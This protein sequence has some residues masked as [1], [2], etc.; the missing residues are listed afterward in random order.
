M[1][2]EPWQVTLVSTTIGS[3][4]GFSSSFIIEWY[5]KKKPPRDA[6]RE[7]ANQIVIAAKDNVAT[8]QNV[9]DLLEGRLEKE[10]EYYDGL[11]ERSKKDCQN[12]ITDMK[13]QYD[14]TI[15]DLQAQIIK[16]N[17]EKNELSKQVEKLTV[18]KTALQV[19]VSDLKE[20]LT[21]YEKKGTGP[22]PKQDSRH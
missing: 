20:R 12:Q 1:E 19:E 9:I 17:S 11:I 21:K 22:L 8:T 16:G 2:L 3:L 18:E 13:Q 6:D 14:N 7:A 4:V 5:K 10:R 15:E